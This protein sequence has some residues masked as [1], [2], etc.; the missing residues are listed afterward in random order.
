M[1][2]PT[3]LCFKWWTVAEE[4][5]GCLYDGSAEPQTLEPD[6]LESVLAAGETD[7]EVVS[8]FR[9]ITDV[10]SKN[11][12]RN[13][14]MQGPFGIVLHHTGG[15]FA[16]DIATLTKPAANPD[17]S[18]SSNDYITKGGKIYELCEYPKRAWHAGDANY[19]GI[20][21][22][23]THGWGIEI[24]NRGT[25]ADPYP[26]V[27][28]D[29]IVWRCR[30]RRRK[31]GIDDPKMLTRHRDICVPKGRK[32]DTSD[33]FPF[34]EVKRRVFAKTDPTD[35]GAPLPDTGGTTDTTV[36]ADVTNDSELLAPPR[37]TR[38]EL[39]GYLLAHPHGGYKE[40]TVQ[41]IA[42]LYFKVARPVGLDPLVAAA[43]MVLETGHLSSK[44]SQPPH[45]NPAGIGVTG[46]PGKGL[47][48]PDWQT[49]VRAHCGR[50]L[51]YAIPKGKETPEQRELI[52]EALKWRPLPDSYRGSAPTLRGLAKRWAT[53][54]KYAGKISRVANEIRAAK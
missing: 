13:R 23:N 48:F 46:E 49:A 54:E 10:R 34:A 45:R 8:G 42:R 28:I 14:Q 27:Q 7:E 51:A 18:V 33:G 43:Q 40:K 25:P 4:S 9:V 5:S 38:A 50:L 41:G 53:D 39:E 2:R 30:E 52:E 21:D 17:K 24:E 26:Q 12:S 11:Y 36:S 20:T 22:W 19:G 47:S 29:A 6:E 16:G 37:A 3:P 15:A 32:P 31:L 35:R 44:W 1:T